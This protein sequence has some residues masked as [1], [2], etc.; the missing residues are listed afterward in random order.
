MIEKTIGLSMDKFYKK[1]EELSEVNKLEH[2]EEIK[3]EKNDK[4]E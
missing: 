4:L 1:Q 3:Q 2:Q